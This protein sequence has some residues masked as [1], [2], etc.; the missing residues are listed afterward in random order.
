[1]TK[2][3]YPF[4]L[5]PEPNEKIMLKLFKKAQEFLERRPWE[6]IQNDDTFVVVDPVSGI[7]GY[8]SIFSQEN[9]FVGF[10][11]FLGDEAF[12]DF[13]DM[14]DEIRYRDE[15]FDE[16]LL[17]E[18]SVL[19]PSSTMNLHCLSLSFGASDAFT[20]TEL[21][22]LKNSKIEFKPEEWPLFRIMI[23]GFIPWVFKDEHA[24]FMLCCLEQV[25]AV[26]EEANQDPELVFNDFYEEGC[27]SLTRTPRPET[28]PRIWQTKYRKA[29]AFTQNFD[30]HCRYSPEQV[31]S[32][33]DK[34]VLTGSEVDFANIILPVII[35]DTIPFRFARCLICM[36]P[37]KKVPWFSEIL[38][39]EPDHNQLALNKLLDFLHK[40]DTKPETIRILGVNISD[41]LID[42]LADADI[43]INWVDHLPNCLKFAEYLVEKMDEGQIASSSDPT[44][45]PRQKPK[46]KLVKKG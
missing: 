29:K 34:P 26:L 43:N 6:R 23:P 31:A 13:M 41:S 35:E 33:G 30:T 1:M 4:G 18:S 38:P 46:L 11:V 25:L 20:D 24:D 5:W 19:P 21:A 40:L 17:E 10:Q 16:D 7:N 14:M 37:K 44:S 3:Q 12:L 32:I 2:I 28:S 27:V 22:V 42:D 15:E 8:C 45:K 9:R 39:Y 36:D